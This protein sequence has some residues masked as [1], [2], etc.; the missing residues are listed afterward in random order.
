MKQIEMD[1]PIEETVVKEDNQK[2]DLF[3]YKNKLKDLINE[4]SENEKYT[5]VQV[6]REGKER[7]QEAG[8]YLIIILILE[9]INELRADGRKQIKKRDI[10]IALDKIL[11]KSSAIE[12]AIEKLNESITDLM[13]I[14]SDSSLIKASDFINGFVEE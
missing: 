5:G 6:S 14:N 13:N 7:I 8:K 3:I 12:I 10:D 1:L 11:A 9:V 4:L 2:E